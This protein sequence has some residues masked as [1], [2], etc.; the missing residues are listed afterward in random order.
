MGLRR[1]VVALGCLVAALV[2]ASPAW[3]SRPALDPEI[4]IHAGPS[5]LPGPAGFGGT[6]GFDSRLTRFVYVDVGGLFSPIS[7]ADD[8][9]VDPKLD[10]GE[11]FR[12][13]HALYIT[14]G[15]RIPHRQ[16]VP[17]HWD[18]IFRAGPAMIWSTDL[19]EELLYTQAGGNNRRLEFDAGGSAGAD[20]LLLQGNN[21]DGPGR[22]GARISGRVF[23]FNPFYENAFDEVLV[24][25]PQGSLEL[26]YEF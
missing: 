12:L 1:I 13:R 2:T 25:T 8:F 16:P 11:H 9:T 3:A 15:L 14:P 20:L 22:F 21:R 24:W 19:S 26:L 10:P 7:I 6:I 18:V 5:M 23:L 4:R 17:I